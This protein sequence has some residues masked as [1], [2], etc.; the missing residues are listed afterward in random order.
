MVVVFVRLV[1]VTLFCPASSTSGVPPIVP[2]S[3]YSSVDDV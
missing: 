2:F 1:Y 3:E